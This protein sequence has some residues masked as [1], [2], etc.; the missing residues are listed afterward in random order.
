MN[1]SFQES[2]AWPLERETLPVQREARENWL[3]A[4]QGR[5]V[6]SG[7]QDDPSLKDLLPETRETIL[8]PSETCRAGVLIKTLKLKTQVFVSP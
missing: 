2:R 6:Q 1:F 5:R 8:V 4:E 7:K 3:S